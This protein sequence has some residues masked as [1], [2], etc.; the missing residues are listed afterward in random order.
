[1]SNSPYT[2]TP[3]ELQAIPRYVRYEFNMLGNVVHEWT[4]RTIPRQGKPWIGSAFLDSVFL[5]ARN[6]HDFLCHAP[7]ENDDVVAGHFVRNADGTPWTS[8]LP[9]FES[10]QEDIHKYRHHLTYSRIRLRRTKWSH[11]EIKGIWDEIEAAWQSFLALLPE[12][13][14]AHWEG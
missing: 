8:E 7:R 5:H 10:L 6:V 12:S 4:Q 2:P 3:E 13:E 14:R 9:F 1:M 11:D